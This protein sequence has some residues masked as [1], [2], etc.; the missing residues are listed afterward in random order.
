MI[1]KQ[2]DKTIE[3]KLAICGPGSSGKTTYFKKLFQHYDKD[4]Y[5]IE[6]TNYRTLLYDYGNLD[7]TDKNWNIRIHVY[8]LAGSDYYL[9]NRATALEAVDGLIFIADL[10]KEV[11][12]RN[13]ESWNELKLL[14]GH[15]FYDF[16]ILIA[17]NKSDLEQREK[18]HFFQFLQKIDYKKFHNIESAEICAL[19]DE[20][21]TN[22]FEKIVELTVKELNLLKL[23]TYLS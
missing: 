13:I 5:S 8:T 3:L 14:F 19:Q 1:L 4:I 20:G 11:W 22:S 2:I 15:A 17:F 16:P 12:T 21:I 9:I 23:I 7:I 18:F 10:G 6:N